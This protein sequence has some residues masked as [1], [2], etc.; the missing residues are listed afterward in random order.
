M[1][2]ILDKIVAQKRKEVA[3]NKTLYPEALLE[4]P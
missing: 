2:D 1:S 4:K 3:R